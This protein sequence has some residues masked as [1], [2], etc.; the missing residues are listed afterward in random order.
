MKSVSLITLL[1]SAC[2]ADVSEQEESCAGSR[3]KP[4]IGD[5]GAHGGVKS[6]TIV[7]HRHTKATPHRRAGGS[8]KGRRLPEGLKLSLQ[9]KLLFGKS[10]LKTA[11]ISVGVFFWG[12]RKVLL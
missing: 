7:I 8:T 3:F 11:H 9:I 12:V 2:E 10:A 1:D 4:F 6:N 5:R